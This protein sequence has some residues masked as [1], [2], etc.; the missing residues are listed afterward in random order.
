ME[1]VAG[2]CS[3]ELPE[4]R[5]AEGRASRSFTERQDSGRRLSARMFRSPV[6]LTLCLAVPAAAHEAVT[7]GVPPP[8]PLPRATGPIRMDGDLSDPAWKSAAVI[9]TFFETVFGDNRAP[10][11]KTV[12]YVMYDGRYFYV[13]VRCEDP[14]PERIRAPYA[15]RDAVIGTDD[16]VAIFL[17]TRGDRRSAQE[18]RVSPRGIQG[19][20][21]FNDADGNED[22]AP[23]FYYDTAAK[24]MDWGWSAELRIPL[25]SLRYGK[26]DPQDW[27]IIVWRNYP[28]DFRYGLYTSPEPRGAN[29]LICRSRELTGITGLPSSSHLVAAP[30]ASAQDVA[31]ADAPGR[32]LADHATEKD[33]GLDVKWSPSG[34]SVF[35]GTVN[36]DFSQVEADVAQI[37]VNNRFALFFPEK[38]P[39][40]LEGVDLFD[41]PIHAVYS[42]T[43]TSP[44]WGTRGTGKLGATSYTMLLAQ[45]GGGG[46]VILPAPSTSSLAAQDFR[47]VVG[48]VRM[49]HDLGTSFV[50][51]LYTGREIEGGGHNRVL[52]PDFQWRPSD[53]DRVTGQ[54]LL[55]DT[56]TPDRPDLAEEWD[57]RIMTSH[58]LSVSWIH[59]EPKLDWGVRYRD[60]GD[61][62]RADAGFVPQV[63]Y[64]AADASFGYRLY[65]KGLLSFVRP[66]VSADLEY[67]RRGRLV[68]QSVFPAIYLLGRRNLQAEFDLNV[69]KLRVTDRPLS[70]TSLSFLVQLDPSRHFARVGL[71]GFLGQDVDLDNVRVGSGGRLT[72]TATLR[73][74]DHLTLDLS[75][76]VS[77][78]NV[79]A[80]GR[81]GARLF[82]AQ[83]QRLK[84][85]YNF[86]ARAFVRLIGQYVSTR[87][88]PTLYSQ[89]VPGRDA[90]FSG[91]ALLS[92]RLNWQTALFLGYGDDRATDAAERLVR[93]GRQFFVK[94]SYSFQR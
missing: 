88:D 46:S 14:H 12:A 77:W 24:V 75:S 44:R 71:Q 8:I 90:A 2:V 9:D 92:Y 41:T 26:R 85:T 22:F 51:L 56:T 79:D 50:G 21:V 36:P 7:P 59:S 65:P 13:G 42:R 72:A 84:A 66:Y 93:T 58:A 70:V 39:F 73:P 80:A 25:T 38:R 16:N 67:D 10:G 63:G 35:D 11:V 5:S 47:S 43:I 87:R 1:E 74:S 83:V 78:L 89:D 17:D 15:D 57:G 53:R 18:F 64:R 81:S 28:R 40:F 20:A 19:D 48:V 55:S 54:A 62:F 61:G 60:F 37:A 34:D 29:C 32:S 27:G 33:V 69:N 49:R 6:L 86:S 68:T 91:S 23:D 31:T 3:V 76:A 94:V 4:V 30:Y 45:D 82:T 52:G